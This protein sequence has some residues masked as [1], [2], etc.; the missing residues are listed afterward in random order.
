MAQICQIWGALGRV[1][2][3]WVEWR[4]PVL[5]SHKVLVKSLRKSQLPHTSVNVFFIWGIVRDT[6]KELWR[7]WLL[8]NDLKLCVWDKSI[9]CTCPYRPR[10]TKITDLSWRVDWSWEPHPRTRRLADERSICSAVFA[11][12]DR[13]PIRNHEQWWDKSSVPGHFG[14]F[15]K[16]IISKSSGSRQK[17]PEMDPLFTISYHLVANR[18]KTNTL[19]RAVQDSAVE[20][21]WWKTEDSQGHI[22]ALAVRSRSWKTS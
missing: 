1:A 20:H 8:Q 6:L 13:L 15:V 21:I 12:I 17:W 7:I 22:M 11:T 18:C 5:I 10:F 9:S 3:G 2:G 14:R 19:T 16:K 4:Q